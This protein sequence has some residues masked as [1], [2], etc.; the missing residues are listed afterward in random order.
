MRILMAIVAAAGL[1]GCAGSGDRTAE[2]AGLETVSFQIDGMACPNCAKHIEEELIEV[3][4]V[5]V[6][7]VNFKTKTARVG[8]DPAAPASKQA[9]EGAVAKWKK[10]HFAA[11]EDPECLDPA[12]RQ[13]I[14]RGG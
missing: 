10:E 11:E 7:V 3:P 4:G 14:K 1:V 6:A 13:E 5:K 12:K 8:L 2:F 9:L